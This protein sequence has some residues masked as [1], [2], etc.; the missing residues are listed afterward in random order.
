MLKFFEN[1]TF[2]AK[3]NFPF[4]LVR[5][6]LRAELSIMR[7]EQYIIQAGLE[8]SRHSSFLIIQARAELWLVPTLA[9]TTY[10]TDE[11]CAVCQHIVDR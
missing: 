7:A 10:V 5:L 4:W 1:S 3:I 9:C 6:V 11:H 8:P 2:L